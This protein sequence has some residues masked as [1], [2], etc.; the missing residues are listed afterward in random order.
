MSEKPKRPY[1]VW[2]GD[3]QKRKSIMASS[4][5]ELKEKGGDKLGQTAWAELRV[6]LECDGTEV[7]DDTYL[8]VIERD[9]VLQL[10]N[11]NER[12]LPPGVEA[13]KAGTVE[14]LIVEVFKS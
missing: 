8:Q 3:R 12:W 11:P 6:V 7:E 4:L 13:L 2:S 14:M 9:T 10:L 5:K 1:K